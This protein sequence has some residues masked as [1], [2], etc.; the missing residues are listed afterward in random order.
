MYKLCTADPRLLNLNGVHY[1]YVRDAIPELRRRMGFMRISMLDQPHYFIWGDQEKYMSDLTKET[2]G[3]HIA[4]LEWLRDDGE[5]NAT[6]TLP[7]RDIGA[8]QIDD[9]IIKRQLNG[10]FTLLELRLM[11]KDMEAAWR[12]NQIRSSKV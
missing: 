7:H 3:N 9:G 5:R 11:V 2:S 12:T 6:F 10:E 8:I 4:T 1:T